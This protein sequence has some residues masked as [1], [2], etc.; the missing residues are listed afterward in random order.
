MLLGL[1]LAL[2]ARCRRRWLCISIVIEVFK[3]LLDS[4]TPL[5]QRLPLNFEEPAIIFLGLCLQQFIE[6]I[7]SGPPTPH[8]QSLHQS[9][10]LPLFGLL[11]HLS[12]LAPAPLLK[13]LPILPSA[14]PRHPSLDLH[15]PPRCSD[16]SQHL[17]CPPYLLALRSSPT[18][19][20]PKS[21]V[22]QR[23]TFLP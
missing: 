23:P 1:S 10:H 19:A 13:T 18:I 2:V 3:L 4:R 21:L 15:L 17:Y 20:P 5:P 7:Y 8:V 6:R 12:R 14:C 11:R 22:V 16:P 9:R